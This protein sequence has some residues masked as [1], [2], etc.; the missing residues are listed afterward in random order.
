M[1]AILAGAFFVIQTGMVVRGEKLAEVG[2]SS[3]RFG[4]AGPKA[5]KKT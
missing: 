5:V 1:L 4:G 3:D 2:G